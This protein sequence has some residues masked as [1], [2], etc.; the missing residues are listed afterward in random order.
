MQV[1]T[2]LVRLILVFQF[3]NNAM[4]F[5]D[6]GSRLLQKCFCCIFLYFHCKKNALSNKIVNKQETISIETPSEKCDSEKKVSF[7][8]SQPYVALKFKLYKSL[9]GCYLSEIKFRHL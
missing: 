9:S 3:F 1:M 4:Y 5:N 7:I 6:C 2:K 8:S